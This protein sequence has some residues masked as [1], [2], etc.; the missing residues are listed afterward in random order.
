MNFIDELLKRISTRAEVG[1]AGLGFVAGYLIDLKMALFGLAPGTAGALGAVAGI[2]LKNTAQSISD[3]AKTRQAR[4]DATRKSRREMEH[5]VNEVAILAS[6]LGTSAR[7]LSRLAAEVR[8]DY[9]LWQR[10]LV[11][12]IAVRQTINE[13]VQRYRVHRAR[14]REAEYAEAAARVSE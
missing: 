6:G 10:G 3:F 4:S 2:G 13:F 14:L 8:Q 7:H 1:V 12:E 11:E 5:A 9:D